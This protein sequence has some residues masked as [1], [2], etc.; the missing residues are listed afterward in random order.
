MSPILPHW[1]PFC[2]TQALKGTS[3][4]QASPSTPL[5]CWSVLPWMARPGLLVLP[6][7]RSLAL[8]HGSPDLSPRQT[9]GQKPR[10]LPGLLPPG[11]PGVAGA[12]AA[13]G[14]PRAHAWLIQG[15]SRRSEV[16]PRTS[17][18]GRGGSTNWGTS[19]GRPLSLL[20]HL[21]ILG[22]KCLTKPGG[23]RSRPIL[24]PTSRA[25]GV[26]VQEWAR[27]GELGQ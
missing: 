11:S 16:S 27:A 2:S 25:P 8:A 6:E 13:S 26:F 23:G 24:L 10:S 5:C 22:T 12:C 19:P 4:T 9:R 3:G 1:A 14:R 21:P 7:H 18:S 17:P 20:C 15:S